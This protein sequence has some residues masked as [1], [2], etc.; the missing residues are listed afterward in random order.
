MNFIVRL[1]SI[2]GIYYR[3][4]NPNVA[5]PP[6]GRTVWACAVI[7]VSSSCQIMFHQSEI[8]CMDRGYHTGGYKYHTGG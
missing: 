7:L 4:A 6:E 2:H 8:I 3:V 1:Q 5:A